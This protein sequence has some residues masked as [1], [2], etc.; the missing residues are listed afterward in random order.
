[1]LHNK[2][3]E[4]GGA[5]RN[6]IKNLSW[7]VKKYKNLPSALLGRNI[8]QAFNSFAVGIY[9]YGTMGAIYGFK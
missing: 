8:P 5:D 7:A 9:G 3:T 6:A 1:M 4:R 2:I